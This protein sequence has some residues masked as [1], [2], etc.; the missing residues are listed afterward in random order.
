MLNVF[1]GIEV[2]CCMGP[3]EG[4]ACAPPE[5]VLRAYMEKRYTGTMTEDQRKWCIQEA[6]LAGEGE[7]KWD[8]LE[9]LNT[10][11]LARTVLSAWASYCRSQG[12]L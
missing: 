3:G 11:D 2:A 8:D 1:E 4:C 12:L 5:R 7:H 9:K 6:F 10:S